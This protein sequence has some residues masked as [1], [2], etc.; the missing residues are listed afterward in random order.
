VRILVATVL[1]ACALAPLAPAA[2]VGP[3]FASFNV[4]VDRAHHTVR[5][6]TIV[7][8]D[9]RQVL[10][11]RYRTT[12]RYRCD[13]GSWRTALR[14]PRTTASIDRGWRYP[15]RLS[16]STCTFHATVHRGAAAATS[17]DLPLGL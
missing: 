17:R 13:G 9:G 8:D 11:R 16:G 7:A 10:A 15:T 2:T 1:A 4:R 5:I 3:Q 6:A 12:V 14:T